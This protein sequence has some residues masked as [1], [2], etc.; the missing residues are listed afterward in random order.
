MSSSIERDSD[1]KMITEKERDRDRDTDRDR[2][3][4][5]RGNEVERCSRYVRLLILSRPRSEFA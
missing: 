5:T 3:R 2:Q 1:G 4:E